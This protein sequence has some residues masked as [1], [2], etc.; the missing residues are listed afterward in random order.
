MI[1]FLGKVVQNQVLL[2]G[3]GAE[4]K[5]WKVTLVQFIS[6]FFILPVSYLFSKHW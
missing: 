6:D 4:D 1:I 2:P 3:K 5:M